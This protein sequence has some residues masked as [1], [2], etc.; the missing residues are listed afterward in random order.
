MGEAANPFSNFAHYYLTWL[1][2]SRTNQICWMKIVRFFTLWVFFHIKK[3]GYYRS[4]IDPS[5]HW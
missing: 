1:R 4:S 2:R 3:H 5:S